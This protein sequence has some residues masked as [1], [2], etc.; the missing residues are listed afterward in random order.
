MCADDDDDDH[1]EQQAKKEGGRLKAAKTGKPHAKQGFGLRKW[2][3]HTYPI[4]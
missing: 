2:I 4:Y 3:A 1:D